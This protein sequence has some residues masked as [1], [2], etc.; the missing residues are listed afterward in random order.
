MMEDSSQFQWTDHSLAYGVIDP[1]NDDHFKMTAMNCI[2]H[3]AME[4]YTDGSVVGTGEGKHSGGIGVF[5][6]DGSPKNIS[7]SLVMRDINHNTME[8]MAVLRSLEC[9]MTNKNVIIFTDSTFVLTS[10]GF[11]GDGQQEKN[12]KEATSK[13]MPHCETV[14]QCKEI[15][16]KRKSL[17]YH[18]TIKYVK[19]HNGNKGNN[20]ADRLASAASHKFIN[21]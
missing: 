18:T 4:I 17:G 6:E 19:A 7:E 8:I 13:S 1:F 2:C 10:L 3:H 5:F 15:I 16:N 21:E 11:L 14:S 9:T 20:A 12:P